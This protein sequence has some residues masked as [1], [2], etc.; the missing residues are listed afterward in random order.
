[1]WTSPGGSNSAIRFWPEFAAEF[2]A[3]KPDGLL[4]AEA[5]ARDPWYCRNGFDAAYDWTDALGVWAW[6]G[7]FDGD[8]PISQAIT[9]AL[10]AVDPDTLVFRFLNNNDTGARF[11]TRHGVD[12]YRVALAM[13]LTM[14]GLPCLYLGDEVGAEFEPYAPDGTTAWSDRHQL[15]PHVRKL[16]RLRRE[17]PGFASGAWT[18]L[19]LE[20]TESLFAYLRHRGDGSDLVLVLLN[21]SDLAAETTID[22]ALAKALTGERHSLIDLYN[23]TTLDVPATGDLSVVMPAWGIRILVPEIAP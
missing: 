1:V 5:S 13:L 4:V 12:R 7:P 15:R 19:P 16:V 23:E 11:I 6:D 22:P 10:E 20:P 14:P 8:S 17:L 3:L 21:F 2:R 9:A 18:P